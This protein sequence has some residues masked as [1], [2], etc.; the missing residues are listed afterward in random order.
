[1]RENESERIWRIEER[2]AEWKIEEHGAGWMIEEHGAE[3]KRPTSSSGATI[4]END[5]DVYWRV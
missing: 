4:T 2:G 5:E 3:W 1:M